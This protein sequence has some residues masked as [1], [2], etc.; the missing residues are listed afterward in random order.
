MAIPESQ[1]ETWSHQGAQVSSK[2]TYN[3]IKTA[4]ANHSWPSA[5]N[6][7]VYLQGSYPNATNIYGDSDVDVVVESSNVFYDDRPAAIKSQMGGYPAQYTW[8]E[9]R[10]EVKKALHTHYGFGVV[11]QHDKCVKVKGDGSN[12]LNADVVPCCSYRRYSGTTHLSTGI[13]FWTQGNIQ[14]VNFP[15]L[16][17]SNGQSKNSDCSTN[18]K[19]NLRVFK[20]ARNKAQGF[21]KFPS[22]FLE[23]LFHNIPSEQYG[24]THAY[25]YSNCLEW[26]HKASQANQLPGFF[27]QNGVQLMFGNGL[28][29]TSVT[30]ANRLID[31]MIKLW[32]EWG[33]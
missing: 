2:N 19:P 30:D 9:F 11:S 14:V 27:C 17:L 4:L 12:R 28:H 3:S 26:L 13:T 31:D 24:Y 22:Y 7:D 1:L 32:N 29:Q 25:T 33:S 16:H 6:H 5:M 8:S 10:D 21:G 18:Y 23:C 20:N 15:K